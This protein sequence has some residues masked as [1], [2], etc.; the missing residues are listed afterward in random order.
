[1]EDDV[2]LIFDKKG[3]KEMKKTAPALK[4]NQYAVKLH[5][6]VPDKVFEKRPVPTATLTLTQEHILESSPTAIVS[7]VEVV[8]QLVDAL[9]GKK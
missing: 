1:M 6:T 2:Y 7:P 8:D 3:V 4:S 5:F 9:Q